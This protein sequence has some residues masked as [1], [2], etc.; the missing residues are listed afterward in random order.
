MRSFWARTAT[1]LHLQDR[2]D[3]EM[4]GD[5]T[6][7]S[8]QLECWS[9]WR[10]VSSTS[11]SGALLSFL[12]QMP[13][14]SISIHFGGETMR[15]CPRQPKLIELPICICYFELLSTFRGLVSL[16]STALVSSVL[17]STNSHELPR[18]PEFAETFGDATLLAFLVSIHLMPFYLKWRIFWEFSASPRSHST[19]KVN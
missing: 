13:L 19:A 7:V 9:R 17:W 18:M 5:N 11:V 8:T 14:V 15:F 4:T 1:Y 3:R 16:W 10:S 2:N 12:P 6:S